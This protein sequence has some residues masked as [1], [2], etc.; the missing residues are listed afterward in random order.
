MDFGVIDKEGSKIVD[1]K[2]DVL[3]KIGDKKLLK[4]V[5]MGRDKETTIVYSGNM[6]KL[7]EITDA[8][9]SINDNYIEIY[10]EKEEIIINNDG[11]IKTAKEIFEKNK[12]FSIRK[13][14]KCGFEDKDGK[15]VVECTYDDV[16]EFN[17]F[18]Y[19][20][21]KKDGKWGVVDENGNIVC[22]PKFNFGEDGAR[23][24]FIEKYYRTYKENNDTY[25]TD[26]DANENTI[27]DE[28]E[29]L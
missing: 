28:N 5:I 1:F 10:N 18:G 15:I 13:N 23:P 20:G 12:L 25:Y 19:A 3:S 7:A 11:E 2:Y 22:E 6:E 16:T 4:A 8:S 17:R 24:N 29:N 26:A 21:I 9:I 27:I 14:G